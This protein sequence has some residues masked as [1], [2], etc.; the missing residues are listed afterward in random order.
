M[1]LESFLPSL[2]EGASRHVEFIRTTDAVPADGQ[3]PRVGALATASEPKPEC[4]SELSMQLLQGTS[5]DVVS[6]H[7]ALC[8]VHSS[9]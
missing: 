9:P 8:R 2:T 7:V 6:C 5:N 1:L 3:V 4:L